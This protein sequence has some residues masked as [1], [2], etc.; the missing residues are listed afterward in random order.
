[1]RTAGELKFEFEGRMWQVFMRTVDGCMKMDGRHLPKR[2]REYLKRLPEPPV[3][4]MW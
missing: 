1:M 2:V 3:P 4:W